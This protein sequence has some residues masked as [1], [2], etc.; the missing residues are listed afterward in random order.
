MIEQP[1]I[2]QQVIQQKIA[3]KGLDFD[4]LEDDELLL[5]KD[6]IEIIIKIRELKNNRMDHIKRQIQEEKQELR[7]KMIRD[8]KKEKEKIIE[9][10]KEEQEEE[11]ESNGSIHEDS[12]TEIAAV[13]YNKK[14]PKGKVTTKRGRPPKKK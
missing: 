10:I 11:E 1:K 12:E 6:E 5:I 13:V 3:I 14:N 7:K 2:E 9:K 8:L 4:N